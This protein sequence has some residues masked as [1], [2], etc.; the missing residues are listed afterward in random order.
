MAAYSSAP[1]GRTFEAVVNYVREHLSQETLA[2]GERLPPERE[3]ARRLNVSRSALREG[4]RTLEMGGIVELRTGRAGGAFVTRGNPKV[5][6]DSMGDLLRLGTV[7]WADLAEARLWIEGVI[8]RLACERATPHDHVALEENI[9]HAMQLFESGLLARKTEVLIEFHN[10]L[11]RTTRNPV[12]VMIMKTL[13][14]M[15]RYFTRRLGSDT[16]RAVFRS[17][18]RFMTAFAARDA[19]SAVAEMER[20]LRKVHRLYLGLAR[21]QGKK[22]GASRRVQPGKQMV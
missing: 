22:A 20:N 5:L 19:E 12:L 10:I 2:P 15:L 6:S 7:S 9:A 4:L 1:G 13:T 18:R 17:R 3:L 21:A 14:D 16:T 8:V 11:A